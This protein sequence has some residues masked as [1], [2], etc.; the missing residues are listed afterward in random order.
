MCVVSSLFIHQSMDMGCFHN[1]AIVN[2]AAINTGVHVFLCN[3]VF[4]FEDAWGAWP[5]LGLLLDLAGV[6]S[7]SPMLGVVLI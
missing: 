3:N 6:V 7:L 4:V 5:A 1:L 2:N